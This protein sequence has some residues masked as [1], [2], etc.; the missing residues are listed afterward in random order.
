MLAIIHQPPTASCATSSRDPESKVAQMSRPQTATT[1]TTTTATTTMSAIACH[2]V[3]KI[4]IPGRLRAA[5]RSLGAEFIISRDIWRLFRLGLRIE[6]HAR[7]S[8][9]GGLAFL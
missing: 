9:L 5:Q 2:G 7:N 4:S 6:A 3:T 1:I 8:K